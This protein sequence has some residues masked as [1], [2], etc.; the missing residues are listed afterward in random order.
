MAVS[1]QTEDWMAER[2]LT[3]QN[4]RL[5][6]SGL[7]PVW[8]KQKQTQAIQYKIENLIMANRNFEVNFFS[9]RLV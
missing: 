5:L 9:R 6:Q 8:K 7:L 3:F 1:S 4:S 2:D